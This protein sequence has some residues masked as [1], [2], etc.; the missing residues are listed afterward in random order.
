MPL[1]SYQLSFVQKAQEIFYNALKASGR[2]GFP[3][4]NGGSTFSAFPFP[5]SE[6]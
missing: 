5:T 3:R 2:T 1:D 4:I 6:I